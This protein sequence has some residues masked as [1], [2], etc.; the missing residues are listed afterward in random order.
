LY[1]SALFG[2]LPLAALFHNYQMQ[3]FSAINKENE[4]AGGFSTASKRF[5]AGFEQ[6]SAYSKEFSAGFNQFLAYSKRFSASG[7][8]A[9]AV[10]SEFN[11]PDLKVGV[12]QGYLNGFSHELIM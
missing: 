6:F 7:I 4:G 9:K 5:S 2:E 8:M 3:F 12:N 10:S 11:N 1:S